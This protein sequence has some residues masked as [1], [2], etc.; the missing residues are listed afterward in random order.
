MA[1]SN[2]VSFDLSIEEIIEDAFERCGGQ[3]RSGY[4][5]KSARRSL[6]ILLAEWGNRG[7]HFWEVANASIKLNE[8][9]N[10]YRIYKDATARD[11]STTYPAKIGD[12]AD[13]LYNATDVLE[14]VYRNA[15]TSPT[16]VTM[17]KVDRS[18]Y[19]A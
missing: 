12:S 19:Q 13:Y 3:G 8:G 5:L 15:L 9:Q 18:T 17:T 4:D 14:I 6:N 11:S 2:T 10:V 1:T 7:L 16:D